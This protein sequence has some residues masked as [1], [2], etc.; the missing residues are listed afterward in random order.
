MDDHPFAVNIG[1]LQPAH[2]R[3]AHAC[4]YKVMSMARWYRLLAESKRRCTSAKLTRP[5]KA[6]AASALGPPLQGL[7]VE[8]TQRSYMLF[9][10]SGRQVPIAKEVNLIFEICAGPRR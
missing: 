2:L 5:A 10:G 8:E 9:N 6:A 1:D 3:S 4:E 7:N